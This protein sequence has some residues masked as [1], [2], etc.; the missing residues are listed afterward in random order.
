MFAESA[1]KGCAADAGRRLMAES[2]EEMERRGDDEKRPAFGNRHLQDPSR[3]YEHNA[4]S[5]DFP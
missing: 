4:W 2:V 1:N 3:V 5:A